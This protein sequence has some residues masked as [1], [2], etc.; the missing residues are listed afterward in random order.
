MPV[1]CG[2]VG[3]TVHVP[4]CGNEIS[5]HVTASL[6]SIKVS[7]VSLFFL[8]LLSIL[9]FPILPC[10]YLVTLAL[11]VA[12]VETIQSNFF[13][14]GSPLVSFPSTPLKFKLTSLD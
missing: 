2:F 4:E 6:P 11:T 13:A 1:R 14:F 3:D 12:H 8:D 9:R 7:Y 5:S 10:C